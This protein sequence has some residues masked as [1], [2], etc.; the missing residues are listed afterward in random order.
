MG[1]RIAAG[2][3]VARHRARERNAC[4]WTR[5]FLAPPALLNL[6]KLWAVLVRSAPSGKLSKKYVYIVFHVVT[7]CACTGP[8]ESLSYSTTSV[9]CMCVPTA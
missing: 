6:L 7:P 8:M 1:W 5:L 2:A 4:T 3:Q 9:S